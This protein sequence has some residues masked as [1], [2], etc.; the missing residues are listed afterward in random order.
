MAATRPQC[1]VCNTVEGK[2]KCPLCENLTCSLACSQEHRDNHPVVEEK[3]KRFINIGP[4]VVTEPDPSEQ[5]QPSKLSD[6]ADTA[7]YKSLL[8]RY[9]DLEKYLWS[10]A[11]ATDPP[12]TNQGGNITRKANQP[13]T[14]EAGMTNAV[15]LVQSIKASPG[16]VRDAIRE[17][18]DLVSI[19][20]ARIQ[21]QDDEA[22]KRRAQED[23]K[24]IGSLLREEKS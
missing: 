1:L 11:T 10:I 7:E 8:Q 19:F 24:I 14:R 5:Q 12:K 15:Q 17:F 9:P 4:A 18:S 20:K 23:A 21:T 2:Y 13:W 16:D 6:I 22:R 3:P